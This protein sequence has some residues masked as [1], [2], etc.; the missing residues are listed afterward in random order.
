VKLNRNLFLLLLLLLLPGC[1]LAQALNLPVS[2]PGLTQTAGPAETAAAQPSPTGGTPAAGSTVGVPGNIADPA[3][4]PGAA[5][6]AEATA[7][8]QAAAVPTPVRKLTLWIPPEF[9]PDNGTTAGDLLRERLNDF[10]LQ[11][12]GV[13]VE[14]RVKAATGPGGLLDG[15]SAASAVA[16]LAL[17]SVVA[18]PRGDLET[19]ALKGLIVP[20]DGISTAI[21]QPDWYDYS[22]QLAMV[23]GATFALPF[24]GDA[25]VLAYRPASVFAPPI[26]WMAIN[27][28]SQP[29]AFPAGDPQALFVLTLY[30]SIGGTV[31]DSQR[32]PALQPDLLSQ[33]LQVLADGEQRGIF[34]YW[35]SQYETNGQVWQAYRDLRVNALVVWASNYLSSLPPD[36]IAVPLPALEESPQTLATSW[37]WAVADPL[38]ERRALS[39]KLVEFLADGAFLARWTEAAGYMPTRPSSL[40]AWSN[41]SLKTLLSPVAVSAQARPSSDLLASLGP[42]LEEA[43]LKVLKRESDP[44]QAAQ[45]AAERLAVPETK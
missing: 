38:P 14:V 26:D 17:P 42:V 35:L 45:A 39:V 27:R 7:A 5:A 30:Q 10:S 2:L 34:P 43:T 19:A 44:T 31:E 3:S 22:R 25:L 12:G 1:D 15:L 36:T 20:L 18:L 32:R 6:V 4:T 33:V 21:D 24:A 23:Q 28:L 13:E 8:A 40:A 9:D 29:L 37:G 16:P 41:Q 11:N